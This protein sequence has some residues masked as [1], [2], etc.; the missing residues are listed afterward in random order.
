MRAMAQNVVS[1]LSNDTYKVD[2]AG[3]Y[4]LNIKTTCIQPSG[5]VI[6]LSQTGSTSASVTSAT[7]SPLEDHVEVNGKFNCASG[8]ILH[9]V[10]T[11]S[12]P[13]DQ[14]PNLIKTTINLKQGV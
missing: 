14:P 7:T 2:T 3:V 12:A 5:L 10:V 13:V 9:V 8:D 11:S 6:T 1:G 4:T